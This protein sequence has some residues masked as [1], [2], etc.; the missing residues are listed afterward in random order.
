[1]VGFMVICLRAGVCVCVRA[2]VCCKCV[3]LSMK[4]C[5]SGYARCPL[6]VSFCVSLR[7]NESLP[8]FPISLYLLTTK[9]ALIS[10]L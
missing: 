3:H 6:Y 8:Q 2:Y 7:V 1:M 5:L 4:A 9:S 10:S